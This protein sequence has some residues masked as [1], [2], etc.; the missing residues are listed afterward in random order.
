M[1]KLVT[2]HEMEWDWK[3]RRLYFGSFGIGKSM[4]FLEKTQYLLVNIGK[5]IWFIIYRY[6]FFLG[7]ALELEVFQ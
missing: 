1:G 4:F 2:P 7:R 3:L 6:W 5:I